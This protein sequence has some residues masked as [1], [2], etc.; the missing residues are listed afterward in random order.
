MD[1]LP[2]LFL[3]GAIRRAG[4]IGHDHYIDIPFLSAVSDVKTF[5]KELLKELVAQT[6]AEERI[7]KDSLG[8]SLETYPFNSES[9]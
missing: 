3:S 8:V 1:E 6:L 2:Q 9:L 4:R 5:L 7:R